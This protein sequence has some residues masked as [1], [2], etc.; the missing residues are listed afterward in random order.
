MNYT[1]LLSS[2]ALL[3]LA[4][5]CTEPPALSDAYGN[6]EAREVIV[7]A[8][9]T[10]KLLQL[11]IAEG[12]HLEAGQAVGLIDTV[13]LDLRRLQLQS[14][15]AATGQKTQDASA[16]IA[17]L[18][19]Q[20]QHLEREIR[21]TAALLERQAATP[22][23]LDDLKDQREI[24]R[25]QILAAQSQ[26]NTANRSIRAEIAPLKA[27]IHQVEDQIARCYLKNPVSGTVL[28]K[29]AEGGEVAIA[30]KPLYKIA[31]LR[32]MT[33]RAYVSGEQLPK[34]KI[35]QM[36]KVLIDESKDTNRALSGRLAWISDQAEFTP[37]T[38]QTKAARVNLVYAV[39]ILVNNDGSLKIGM[40]GEVIFP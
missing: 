30:G 20:G 11:N 19:A 32:Q 21:R 17:V 31:D 9:L 14:I 27:Q 4:P 18:E 29:L 16:Q 33:L 35:G 39:K 1:H 13:P 6:F 34:I 12:Q 3:L 36:V 8:E 7:A 28:A 10:G 24:V 38:I 5:G 2:L 37:K 23:Q 40:P 15:I 26:E 25:R 22:Q